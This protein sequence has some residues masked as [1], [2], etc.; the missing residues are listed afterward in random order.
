MERKLIN[1]RKK[2]FVKKINNFTCNKC[3]E[4]KISEELEI[5]HIVPIV[6]GGTNEYSNLQPLCI[7]C[8]ISKTRGEWKEDFGRKKIVKLNPEEKLEILKE[9]LEENKDKGYLDIQFLVLNDKLLST[10]NYNSNILSLL[11]R[12]INGRDPKRKDNKYLM[13]RNKILNILREKTKMTYE[14]LSNL[15]M[16]EGIMMT[17]VQISRICKDSE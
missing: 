2:Y 16:K 6:N 8:H 7:E 15:L 4:I 12:K 13:Q 10:F 17:H 5:D 14:K 3:G 9:F 11:F 1:N